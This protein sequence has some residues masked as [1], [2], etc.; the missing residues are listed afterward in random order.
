MGYLNI[1][2]NHKDR[3]IRRYGTSCLRRF[4][5]QAFNKANDEESDGSSKT[6]AGG[7]EG[8]ENKDSSTTKKTEG[9][10]PEKKQNEEEKTG[11]TMN[12]K[13]GKRPSITVE[14][15][16]RE[17]NHL[18]DASAISAAESSTSSSSRIV[19]MAE[20]ERGKLE[21]HLLSPMVDF[22][23]SKYL[24]T[25]TCT[26]EVLF[27]LLQ[28]YG[29]SFHGE[30][31]VMVLTILSTVASPLGPA[32]LRSVPQYISPPRTPG[33]SAEQQPSPGRKR[34]MS[35]AQTATKEEVKMGLESLQLITDDFL[36]T[37]PVAHVPI[38][39][40]AIELL[41]HS[42]DSERT[43][44]KD[45]ELGKDRGTG[46]AVLMMVHYSRD[47]AQKQWDETRVFALRAIAAMIGEF[48]PIMNESREFPKAWA[49]FL[50][51]IEFCVLNSNSE[52]ATNAILSLKTAMTY[53][54]TVTVI[55]KSRVVW[56]MVLQLY[57]NLTKD[58]IS[59]AP[60]LF[61]STGSK[62]QEEEV[63]RWI[64]V[65]TQ[66]VQSLGP[67]VAAVRPHLTHA[68]ISTIAWICHMILSINTQPV[69]LRKDEASSSSVKSSPLM[70]RLQ[71]QK[72]SNTNLR[73]SVVGVME[74]LAPLPP[75]LWNNI[76][77]QLLDYVLDR[78]SQICNRK[79]A[80]SDSL[81]GINGDGAS[82]DRRTT[83]N[84]RAGEDDI[85]DASYADSATRMRAAD[86]EKELLRV[87][88][89]I[90]Q[91]VHEL[92]NV[93]DAVKDEEDKNKVAE[94][95]LPPPPAQ[96]KTFHLQVLKTL[97][98]LYCEKAPILNSSSPA[99]R[100]AL[101]LPH[102]ARNFELVT[103]AVVAL[104]K[105]FASALPCMQ[106]D[107]QQ[108]V[109]AIWKKIGKEKRRNPEITNK[110]KKDGNV[111]ES[112]DSQLIPLWINAQSHVVEG[113]V[114]GILPHSKPASSHIQT[115]L[116]ALLGDVACDRLSQDTKMKHNK[117]GSV[118]LMHECLLGLFTLCHQDGE[119]KETS[120]E[121]DSKQEEL[122]QEAVQERNSA[123][124]ASSTLSSSGA[125][126]GFPLEHPGV[127]DQGI[128]EAVM[129]IMLLIGQEF[130]IIT[131]S[132]K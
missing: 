106:Y 78:P 98:T 33:S 45:K 77:T 69:A 13:K 16:E 121:D 59:R 113:L 60:R 110:E 85:S 48:I 129:E 87:Y 119:D 112:D 12:N 62:I 72:C 128:R 83:R 38:L 91:S 39:I 49:K 9:E 53:A 81:S 109:D 55:K 56:G 92:W 76:I 95:V 111:S 4:L 8:G 25:R 88:T 63:E 115:N 122:D 93:F 41:D 118:A 79:R 127:Q 40:K 32:A 57:V 17:G 67:I 26:L 64:A 18:G 89:K 86:D 117:S 3:A 35:I 107:S 75:S 31:W 2:M 104:I 15:D 42:K 54:G 44:N 96:E 125:N 94:R 50:K 1:M 105:V 36:E 19:R 61:V 70:M 97:T 80:R 103:E 24:D 100:L 120:K 66:L 7:V 5:L 74:V 68:D 102:R 51:H 21:H 10:T 28:S 65:V 132:V 82:G 27:T 114:S 58:A 101:T 29:H 47:T 14:D 22:Y 23:K 90:D 43:D 71:R 123:A 11:A 37:I 84:E 46:E 34:Q 52:V 20:I 116:L 126:L 124:A 30:G 131:P 99:W 6:D 108:H 73:V 130:G